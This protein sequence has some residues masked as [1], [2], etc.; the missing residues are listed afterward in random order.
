MTTRRRALLTAAAGACAA[1][2]MPSHAAAQWQ[3]DRPITTLYAMDEEAKR[4]NGSAPV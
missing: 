1:S 3:P 2:A 4:Q